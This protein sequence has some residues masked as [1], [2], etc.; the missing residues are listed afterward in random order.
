MH[1]HTRKSNLISWLFPSFVIFYPCCY[2]CLCRY[3]MIAYLLN[4]AWQQWPDIYRAATSYLCDQ[5]DICFKD[6]RTVFVYSF[7]LV[8]SSFS[9]LHVESEWAHGTAIVPGNSPSKIVIWEPCLKKTAIAPFIKKCLK[10]GG[11]LVDQLSW[12]ALSIENL[13]KKT[14]KNHKE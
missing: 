1:P 8:S 4:L 5:N 9:R 10:F 7:S 6:S 14:G 2:L 12:K 11:L 13:P 3:S